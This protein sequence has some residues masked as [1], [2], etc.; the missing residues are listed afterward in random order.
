MK[1]FM[2]NVLLLLYPMGQ[3]MYGLFSIADFYGKERP[4][5]SRQAAI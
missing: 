5:T 3:I 4:A 1:K 2:M